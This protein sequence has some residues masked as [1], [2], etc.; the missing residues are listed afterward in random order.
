MNK[1][2]GYSCEHNK[3]GVCQIPVCD[4]KLIMSDKIELKENYE[5]IYNENCKLREEHN[6]TDISLLDENQ[7]LKQKYLNAAADYETTM[8]EL[9]ELK[10][11]LEQINKMIEKCGFVNIEQV[12]LN[13]CGLLTQQKEFIKW[14]EDEIEKATT[15]PYTKLSEYGMNRIHIYKEILQKYKEIIGVSDENTIK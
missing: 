2:C 3:G 13:Y 10:K 9:K 7:E 14:L 4:K 5:R 15:N 8:S 1:I 12:M 11:Q 6:I